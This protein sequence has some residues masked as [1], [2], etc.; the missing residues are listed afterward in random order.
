MASSAGKSSSDRHG[1]ARWLESGSGEIPNLIKYMEAAQQGKI[2]ISGGLKPLKVYDEQ[3]KEYMLDV[4]KYLDELTRDDDKLAIRTCLG[5]PEKLRLDGHSKEDEL[6]KR[7][8]CKDAVAR[9]SGSNKRQVQLIEKE[10]R[11][12]YNS[13][14]RAETARLKSATKGRVAVSDESRDTEWL[15]EFRRELDDWYQRIIKHINESGELSWLTNSQRPGT[16]N[17]TISKKKVTK[18]D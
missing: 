10:I 8:R 18:K 5:R 17:R 9:F 6:L 15:G 2:G 13:K 3:I 7:Q 14:L 12:L 11:S 4:E 16:K 1:M